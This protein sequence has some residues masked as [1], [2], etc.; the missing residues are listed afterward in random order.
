MKIAEIEERN[1]KRRKLDNV[2][3]HISSYSVFP[4]YYIKS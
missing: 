2:S 1:E 4:N 3:V